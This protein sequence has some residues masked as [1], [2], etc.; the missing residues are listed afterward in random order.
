MK[1]RAFI[2]VLIF[3]SVVYWSLLI[4]ENEKSNQAIQLVLVISIDQ[5]RYEYLPR[6]GPLFQ[7]GLKTLLQNGAVFTEA[8]YR[9]ANT[10]TGPGHSV[11]LSG[12]HA[13]HS[14]IIANGW[15]DTFLKKGVNVV[16]DPLQKPLGGEGRA[17]SP[18]NFI[19]FT[20]GDALKSRFP[21]TKVVGVSGK[22]RSAILLAGKLADGAFWYERAEG[23]FI[24]STYYMKQPPAWLLAWNNKRF[25]D[26]FFGKEWIRLNPDLKLYE[27]F[28]GPDAVEGEWDRKDTV[29]PHKIR[30]TQHDSSFY[31]DFLRTPFADQMILDFVMEARKVYQLGNDQTPDI[32]AV[33]FSATDWIGHTYGP[34]SQEAMD[35]MLRLDQVL[36]KLFQEID[37]RV[38]LSKTIVVLT[39]DHG[40]L[41][42][43]EV[44]Q[45]KKIPA[46]RVKYSDLEAQVLAD[47]Q[48]RFPGK[49]GLIA[50]SEVPNFWLD[51]EKIRA[52]GLKLGEV[53]D[54][55]LQILKSTGVMEVVYKKEDFFKDP[56]SNDPYFS[57][58]Q[59]SFFAPR[60]PDILGTVKKYIYLDDYVG[61]T[62]HGTPYDYD[63]HVPI[64]FW[65][66]GVKAGSYNQPCG[67]EDIAPTLAT[68]LGLEYPKEEDSRILSEML[69]P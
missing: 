28:A 20:L 16:D 49:E 19:G 54:A 44:L 48:K 59:N 4:A 1:K 18:T 34:D 47:L 65:G 46:K 32:L 23:K 68:I 42:L 37:A 56:P 64:I 9:H 60:S 66:P 11:I 7:S 35:Q 58:F 26:Q 45:A 17:A 8:K 15:Y 2:L 30:G 53:E 5:M 63:R 69:R 41:P 33:S 62:G 43:V 61:G 36:G 25:P 22:D 38:G 57:L 21:E 39:A 50:Y 51:K 31:E 10:E 27:K 14:G 67:P 40:S 13:S 52:A 6:L 3:L 24:T 29:F 55:I 12:R